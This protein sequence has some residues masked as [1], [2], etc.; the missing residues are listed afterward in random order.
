MHGPGRE[1]SLE[2]FIFICIQKKPTQP[3]YWGTDVT[4]QGCLEAARE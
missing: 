3:G 2:T 4:G 1:R